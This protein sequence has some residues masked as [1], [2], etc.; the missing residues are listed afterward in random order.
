MRIEN[1]KVSLLGGHRDKK[2]HIIDHNHYGCEIN[3]SSKYHKD[4]EKPMRKIIQKVKL[5]I[6]S[7]GQYIGHED[8]FQNRNYTY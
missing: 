4:I 6:K 1:K 8:V 3:E 5:G 2:N 7:Q